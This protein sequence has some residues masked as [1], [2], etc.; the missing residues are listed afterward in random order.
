MNNE[1]TH[2]TCCNGLGWFEDSTYDR[3][4]TIVKCGKCKGT[5]LSTL[6]IQAIIDAALKSLVL[7]K[8]K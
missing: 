5:G 7:P 1:E 6:E 4:G 8:I 3:C 2:C